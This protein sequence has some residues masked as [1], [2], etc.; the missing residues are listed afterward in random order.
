MRRVLLA[1]HKFFPAHRAG[2]EVLTLKVAQELMR[3]G[4]SVMVVT[5][6]PPDRDARRV[7]GDQTSDYV[8]EGVPVHVV[9]EPL[10]LAD[11]TFESEFW[12]DGIAHHFDRVLKSFSPDLIHIFHAQNLSASIIDVAERRDLPVVFSAMDFWFV[13]P[14]VQLKRPNGDICRGPR[15]LATNCLSCYTPQLFPPAGE[16]EEAFANK[17]ERIS[18]LMERLPAPLKNISVGGLYGSYVASKIPRAVAATMKRPGVLRSAAN[19]LKSIMVPTRVMKEIFIENGIDEKLIEHVPFGIDTAPLVC[20]QN[21]TKSANLRI[22]YIGTF[23]EHKGVDLL[24]DAFQNLP[25]NSEATLTLY[26]DLQQFP[27]YGQRLV[28]QASQPSANSKKIK[29]AGT[30]PNAMLG[31]IMTELDVLVVPS[32]WYENTP[33]VIQSALATKTPVIATDLGGMSELV[34]HEFNGLL[35]RLNDA[36]SLRQQLLRLT[37]DRSLLRALRDNIRPERTVGEMVDDIESVYKRVADKPRS[38][39]LAPHGKSPALHG[40]IVD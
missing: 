2:T 11:Y 38:P 37:S 19:K 1:V 36:Q 9:E 20:H 3:R 25:E 35:F 14:I 32:R 5:A 24:I 16:F 15:R 28:S 23:F 27:E 18:Q 34:K 8:F 26:G 33:L 4:Y 7:S 21:K 12:H 10:R 40:T 6:N 39:L 13:C 22:G 17:Y 29:F 31:E 30:F